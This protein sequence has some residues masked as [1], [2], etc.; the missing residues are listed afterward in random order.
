MKKY[1]VIIL[2]IF[3]V[4]CKSK[5]VLSEGNAINKM[6]TEKIIENHYKNKVDF[7]TLSI[8]ANA[9]Y[10]DDKQS[11]SVSVEIKIKKDEK[12][13]VIIRFLG[14]TMA[15]AL[16]TPEKVQYYEK[17]SGTYFEG[18]YQSLSKWLGTDLDF[19]KVQ[20]LLIGQAMDD[21]TKAKFTNSLVEKMYKLNTSDGTTDKYFSFEAERFL[22]KEQEIM[23]QQQMRLFEIKYSNFQEFSK[24][25]MP[26]NLYI[27]AVQKKA[28]TIITIDYNTIQFNEEVTFPYSVP[29]DYERKTID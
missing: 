17:L 25:I 1:L 8:R 3:L 24:N 2:L 20:N 16:I 10:K 18:E 22:L 12:I 27:E 21:L 29:D 11:Q 28:K 4:S 14:I 5:A 26:T 15:K 23:Q 7:K 9:K 13:L 19:N 6:T